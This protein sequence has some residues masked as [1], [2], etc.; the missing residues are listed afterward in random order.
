MSKSKRSDIAEVYKEIQDDILAEE[1]IDELIVRVN[2]AEKL[3]KEEAVLLLDNIEQQKGHISKRIYKDLLKEIKLKSEEV[4]EIVVPGPRISNKDILN[5]QRKITAFFK[6]PF[7]KEFPENEKILF[8]IGG[9]LVSGFSHNK[10]SQY[11]GKPSD[12]K[13]VS[14][15]DICVF[16]SPNL[17]NLIFRDKRLI[18]KHLGHRRT[19]PIGEDEKFSINYSGQFRVL[20]EDLGKLTISGLQRK[21][22]FTFFEH[23]LLDI[24]EIHKEHLIKITEIITF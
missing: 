21:V 17:F 12:Y 4:K 15:V 20:I 1:D 13:R 22:N 11:F 24:L 2:S 19:L 23:G 3:T 6:S 5:I 7:A 16:I 14:D 18:E 10:S 8:Y 9:S